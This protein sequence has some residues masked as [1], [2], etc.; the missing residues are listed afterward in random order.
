VSFELIKELLNINYKK[1]T[2]PRIVLFISK[3]YDAISQVMTYINSLLKEFDWMKKMFRY[4]EM[5]KTLYFET[6]DEDG[7][8]VVIS[9]CNFYSAL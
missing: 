7:Q 9:Q 2:R 4:S 1:S 3:D 8:R 5:D 6:Y